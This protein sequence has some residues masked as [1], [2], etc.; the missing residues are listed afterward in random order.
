VWETTY[1]QMLTGENPVTEW[2]KGSVL[3][4]FMNALSEAERN[5][6]LAEYAEKI[7]AAYPQSP[8]GIT[9]LPFTRLFILT[10]L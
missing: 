10:N 3:R 5:E 6:F 7:L 1:Y 4:P 9:T 2:T 8:D